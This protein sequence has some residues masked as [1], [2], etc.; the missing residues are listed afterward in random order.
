MTQRQA[1][2]KVSAEVL[3]DFVALAASRKLKCFIVTGIEFCAVI[4]CTMKSHL[5]KQTDIKV[6]FINQFFFPSSQAC[7]S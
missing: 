2:R 1:E 3:L 4:N 7:D 5:N 6:E